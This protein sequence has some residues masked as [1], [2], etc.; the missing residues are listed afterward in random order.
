MVEEEASRLGSLLSRLDWIARIDQE[1]VAPRLDTVEMTPLVEQAVNQ[2]SRTET[3]RRIVLESARVPVKALADPEL[4]KL[5]LHQM[6]D[7][8]CKFSAPGAA[9]QVETGLEIGAQGGMVVVGVSSAGV[10]IPATEQE[11]IFERFYR[12]SPEANFAA[13][14]GLGLHAARKIA[15]AHGGSLGLDPGRMRSSRIAFRL[16]LRAASGE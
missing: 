13:G 6:L 12:S 2:W 16:C 7:N 1:A 3:D 14:S 11:R 8:A 9:I 4:I 10:P 15:I 5:A